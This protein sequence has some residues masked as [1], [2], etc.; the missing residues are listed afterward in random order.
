MNISRKFSR[1]ASGDRLLLVLLVCLIVG[2][3]T[4]FLRSAMLTFTIP[5][6][7]FLWVMA[8]VVLLVGF[9]RVVVSG[10]LDRGPRSYS[11]ALLAFATALLLITLVSPQPWVSFTGLPSRGAGALTYLLCLG[12]LHVV[13]GMA[14]RRSTEPLAWAFVAAH[15]LVVLYGLL[16]AYG[17]DPISWGFDARFVGVQVFS[18]L[19]NGNFSSGY[20]G[21]TLPL[22]I[23]MAFG[24]PYPEVV[25]VA[26][27]ATVGASV[28]ALTYFNSFQG[29]V[30]ALVACTVLF[31]WAMSRDHGD[32]FVAV[33]VVMPVAFVVVGLPFVLIAP[34][35]LLLLATMAGLAACAG[36]GV[37]HDRKRAN[38]TSGDPEKPVGRWLWPTAI[39]GIVAG[40][41]LGVLF[42]DRIAAELGSGLE[43]RIEFWKASL[44]MFRERPLTG[45]GLET[46]STYFASHR[47]VEHAVQWESLLVDSPHSVP[48]GILSGGGLVLAATYLASFMVIGYFGVL[49]VR[50]TKGQLRL[51]Y[52]AVLT[53]WVAYH[54]Q[55]SVSMDVPGLIY[56]Q[57]ILGGILVAGGAS[58]SQTV[59][60]L[61]WKPRNRRSRRGDG[62]QG[63]RRT[64]AVVGLVI[65]FVFTI[66]PLSAPLRANMAVSRAQAALVV[67]DPRTAEIELAKAIELQPRYGY[68]AESM[69]FLYEQGGFLEAAFAEA[70][71]GARL[72]PGIPYLALKAARLAM[73]VGRLDAAEHWYERVLE[74]D[75]NG[76]IAI[77]E[78]AEFFASH[79]SPDHATDLIRSF[80]SLGTSNTTAWKTAARVYVVLGDD[81]R[82]EEIA[83]C[84]G[85]GGNLIIFDNCPAS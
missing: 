75:P 56:A 37:L 34:G 45:M 69:A 2:T 17:L 65:F 55:A 38:K 64:V 60:E 6:I 27:G 83:T 50:E 47:S 9:Y 1:P 57:W 85:A 40:G 18:T 36:F 77:T 84:Y 30:V 13:Y 71:R 39:A 8:V 58:V 80:E 78:A 54:V 72:Q 15:V 7:T 62:V 35:G 24:S 42:R 43:Q 46:Y 41:S 61:P 76:S 67:S 52:G 28:I 68:Y 66:G 73:E 14:Q 12:L 59:L 3:P 82:A 81:A 44:S 23:W 32:R 20:V 10:E 22:L 79:G 49:A 53:S 25:R 31:Q 26:A 19:G 51:F 5:Q 4:V 21:F 11:V 63:V 70:D 33:L 16:Q 29:Q 48:F 74:S